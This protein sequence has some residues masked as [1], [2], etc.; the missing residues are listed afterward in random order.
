MAFKG[1]VKRDVFLITYA[2]V[3]HN[4]SNVGTLSIVVYSPNYNEEIDELMF[5]GT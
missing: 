5:S 2:V 1:K 4:L 3:M